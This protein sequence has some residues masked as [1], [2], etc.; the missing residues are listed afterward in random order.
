[1]VAGN[2]AATLSQG[3]DQWTSHRS[4]K[5]L[6]KHQAMHSPGCA[7]RVALHWL[8]CQLTPAGDLARSLV[9]ATHTARAPAKYCSNGGK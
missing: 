8:P 1:M 4:D 2:R 5:P 3:L 6:F 7:E 9:C